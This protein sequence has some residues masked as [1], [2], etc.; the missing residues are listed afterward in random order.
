MDALGIMSMKATELIAQKCKR[1]S[2]KNLLYFFRMIYVAVATVVVCYGFDKGY[3]KFISHNKVIKEQVYAL[4]KMKYP[5]V[6]FC[7]KFKHGSKDVV[8]NYYPFLLEI[9][10]QKGN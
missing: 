9:A 10:K 2:V 1:C 5:S 8:Q 6:T 7:Y 3:K 4:D